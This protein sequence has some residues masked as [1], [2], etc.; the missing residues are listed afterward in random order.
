MLPRRMDDLPPSGE[1]EPDI[2]PRRMLCLPPEGGSGES[3]VESRRMEVRSA[4]WSD[5]RAEE[6][7]PSIQDMGQAAAHGGLGREQ[8]G[9]RGR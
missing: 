2:E 8:C 5:F 1:R 3:M 7:V 6:M 9:E 4:S